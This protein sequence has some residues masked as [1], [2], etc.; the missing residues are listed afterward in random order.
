MQNYDV[1]GYTEI[2]EFVKVDGGVAFSAIG[3]SSCGN[4]LSAKA[5]ETQPGNSGKIFAD[6][7]REKASLSPEAKHTVEVLL[8]KSKTTECDAVYRKLWSLTELYLDNN[9]IIDIKPLQSLLN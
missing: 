4:G 8:P 1:Y 2:R 7:C 9:E 3:L 6:W 5:A